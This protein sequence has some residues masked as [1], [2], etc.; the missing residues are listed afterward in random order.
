M[1][2]KQQN[3]SK[4]N[5]QNICEEWAYDAKNGQEKDGTL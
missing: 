4:Q 3:T 1:Y 2:H 5:E